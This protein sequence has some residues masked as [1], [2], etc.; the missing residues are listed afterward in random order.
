MSLTS[1]EV[2]SKISKK[3]SSGF[4]E[5]EVGPE[6]R[7]TGATRNCNNNNLEEEIFIGQ[8][9]NNVYTEELVTED[10]YGNPLPIP[11]VEKIEQIDFKVN[12]STNSYYTLHKVTQTEVPAEIDDTNH[13]LV[14]RLEPKTYNETATLSFFHVGTSSQEAISQKE[15]N[16]TYGNSNVTVNSQIQQFN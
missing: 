3:T 2:V 14:I 6:V 8:D 15:V 13:K 10:Q 11:Y 12:N 4:T 7:Y 9:S 5:Y 16:Y 1:N